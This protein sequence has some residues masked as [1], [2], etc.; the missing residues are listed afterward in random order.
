MFGRRKKE[1]LYSRKTVI[2]IEVI[3]AVLA[4]LIGLGIK[5]LITNQATNDINLSDQT[6]NNITFSGFTINFEKDGSSKINV[7]LINYTK[8]EVVVNS[9]TMKLYAKD[10]TQ[11]AAITYEQDEDNNKIGPNQ[12]VEIESSTSAD[13]SGV[14]FVEYEIK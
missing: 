6:V 3:I 11:I 8:E 4:I 10:N 5:Y 1:K 9:V 2:A 13:L 14:T 12:E 7:S